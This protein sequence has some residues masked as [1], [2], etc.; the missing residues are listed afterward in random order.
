MI[1][2]KGGTGVSKVQA[3]VQAY[4]AG[5]LDEAL[6]TAQAV[7][8][9]NRAE[10]AMAQA[11]IGNIYA[12]R[13]DALGAALAFEQAAAGNPAQ[14][15]VFLKLAAT[16][17]QQASAIEPLRRIG[18]KAALANRDDAEFVLSMA[19]VVVEP[20]DAA[21]RKAACSLVPFMDRKSG[22]AMFF[23][24]NLLQLHGE[25]EALDALLNEVS[26]TLADD[27]VIEGVRLASAH[28]RAD[29][30]TISRHQ[31]MMQNLDSPFNRD[32]LE[33]ED[34][35]NR[36]LWCEN[37]ALLASPNLQS[38]FLAASYAQCPNARRRCRPKG[39]K[40]HIGYLSSDFSAHATMMLMLDG[41]V[42]HDRT[43]FDITLFCHTDAKA[44]AAQA[45]MPALLQ[46]EIVSVRDLSDVEAAVEIDRRGVDILVDLKGHTPGA[47]L[48]IVNLS[49]APIKA[50]W[51]GFPGTVAG[52]DLDYVISDPVV[53]PASSSAF[54]GEKFCRLPETY[55]PNS[56]SSRPK[57]RPL[58]RKQYGL[59]QDA[60]VFASFNG[61][62]KISPQTLDL[63]ARILLAV[64]ESLLWIM[65]WDAF[66]RKNLRAAFQAHGVDPKR[67]H[68]AD[69]QDYA[70]HVN[71]LPLADLALDSFPYNGHTTTSDMLWTG[72]PVVTKKGN[73]FAARVSESLLRAIDL[74]DLVAEDDDAFVALAA[75]LATNPAQLQAV[76]QRLEEHRFKA[77]LFDTD[78]FTRHLET[79]YEMM[80]ERA[81]AGLAPDHMDVPA[82]PPRQTA[83]MG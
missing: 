11:L 43:R 15:S 13:G 31:Q 21:A 1:R 56:T 44:A 45:Q 83:F 82:L 66:A 23:A 25:L 38:R 74:G 35:L 55:Q 34:A 51:L 64:P 2:E 41:L 77:P 53:T 48:G 14:A 19:Q 68:F 33:R 9:K 36:L 75:H 29:F 72:L 52:V 39:E 49:S 40:L 65:C 8:S 79:A 59:P 28:V 6:K 62:Q 73:C 5:H 69:K 63:W 76:K 67:L 46:S 32:V 50:T 47:R 30:A 10:H 27:V 57:A 71:R 60:F 80:A 20:W 54:F 26:E 37:E 22:P 3:A 70:L 42:A 61:V 81:R 18:L 24:A 58:S 7:P 12:K 16:L 78:R 4:Q 17:C